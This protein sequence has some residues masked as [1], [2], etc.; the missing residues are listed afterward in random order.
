MSDTN[1]PDEIQAPSEASAK[2]GRWRTRGWGVLTAAQQDHAI[3]MLR[4]G[5]T[6]QAVA[7]QIG[8][9]KNTIAGIWR[10]E[11]NPVHMPKFGPSTLF[12]RCDAR[13]ARMDAVLAET[14]GVD[15]IVLPPVVK[16]TRR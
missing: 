7:N 16:Q 3:E 1:H 10:R 4:G 12:E 9:T 8:V 6:Q 13:H 5:M 15:R 2:M 14:L 11:G